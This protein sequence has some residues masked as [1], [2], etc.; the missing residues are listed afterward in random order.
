MEA[1]K[2]MIEEL[3]SDLK[4]EL[5]TGLSSVESKL[6][7]TQASIDATAHSLHSINTWR[8]GVDVQVSELTAS[9]QELR[10]QVERV[11]VGVGLSALG[12]PPQPVPGAAPSPAAPTT[13]AAGISLQGLDSGQ[14]GH[15]SSSAHRGQAGGQLS[16]PLSAPVIGTDLAHP[17][18]APP[19]ITEIPS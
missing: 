9:V 11:A 16:I 1:V 18:M 5:K 8:S 3:S 12:P 15:G 17:S 14:I 2:K 7:S 4:G 10:K 13:I 19:P 6:E